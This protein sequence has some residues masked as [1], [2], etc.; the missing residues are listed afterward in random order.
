MK[1]FRYVPVVLLA[2]AVLAAVPADKPVQ[3]VRIEK[4]SAGLWR[5][6]A[7]ERIDVA[8]ELRT[9]YLARA[10]R[11]EIAAL[12]QAGASVRVID[13]D[14][15]GQAFVLWP[16]AG[17]DTRA[18]LGGVG[19]LTEVEPGTLL[20][21]TDAGDPGGLIPP[22][23]KWKALPSTSILPF[24][25][26]EAGPVRPA[27]G[28]GARNDIVD[29]ILA[30]VSPAN[31]RSQVQALQDFQTRYASTA[32]CEAAGQYIYN[33]FSGLGLKVKFQDVPFTE[34]VSRN[35]VAE[36]TGRADP[37]DVLIICSHYDSYS[38]QRLT[39]APGAD[40]NASGTA[41]VMEAGRVLSRTPLDFTVRFAA[42]TAEELGLFGSK[43]YAQDVRSRG[44]NIIGVINLDM[45][46]YA[47]R[48]PE[49]LE[50]ISNNTSS[51]LAARF[52]A[53]AGDYGLAGTRRIIDPSLIYS[54]HSPF[55]DRG[56][57]A[58]LLIEDNPLTNPEY[59][60]TTDTI[61]T[62]DF[63]FYAQASRAAL[64]ALA[65][66]AQPVRPGAPPTPSGLTAASYLYVSLFGA[67]RNTE[68]DWTAVPGAAGYNV[69]RSEISHLGYRRLNSSPLTQASFADR[70]APAESSL[71][72]VVTAV[73]PAGLE[74]NNSAEV[75]VVQAIVP[76]GSK[77]SGG[78]SF[79]TG[80]P[81]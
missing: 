45:I 27:A 48:P 54:D 28:A 13:R 36:L 9:C 78:P 11:G 33:Y 26:P 22:G 77:T 34:G 41:A 71:F 14:L 57:P 37:G 30:E 49:E 75:E 47:D 59:H 70:E 72:Y 76:S 51:W 58:V 19:R 52:A 20:F 56:Y 23:L 50:V 53:V 79:F 80:G 38:N 4:G 32:G 74:S 61:D 24:L 44:D 16:A 64:A 15:G 73:G 8:Q 67:V 40:D 7:E 31:L 66:L 25:R 63:E 65:E 46:A 12:R 55:W 6:L 43:V 62:L 2:A 17:P 35:V 18:V 42:F 81:R 3:L 69:Y 29:R 5:V 60:K 1:G 39:L 10:E 21:W 68:L